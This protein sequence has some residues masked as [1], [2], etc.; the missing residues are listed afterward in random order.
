MDKK[1][2]F[3][4]ALTSLVSFA[5]SNGNKVTMEDV[6]SRFDGLIDDDSQYMLIYDYLTTNKIDIE[7]FDLSDNS[8]FDVNYTDDDN[9]KSNVL[10]DFP[11]SKEELAF[12]DMYM[13]DMGNLNPVS[14]E[15]QMKYINVLLSGDTAVVSNLTEA[16]LPLAADI[17]SKYRGKGASFGDLIQ[18]ANLELMIAISEYNYECG[19]FTTYI[20]NRIEKAVINTINLEINSGRIGQHLADKLNQLDKVTKDLSEDL[21]RVPSTAELAKAMGISE[22][23]V[24]T[25]LKTSLDT[26]SIN[27]DSKIT[28]ME[29]N[30]SGSD[31]SSDISDSADITSPAS[32]KDPLT[33]R[34]HTRQ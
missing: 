5:A 21:G 31:M 11:E 4:N 3:N 13:A 18:E 25:L 10:S 2:S 6:K 23:E 15:K 14:A 28:D 34:K 24:S 9:I 27:E 22:D 26:L 19:D 7:G 29:N 1:I 20:S 8:L 32:G 12:I 17:A 16:N 33:W 30:E